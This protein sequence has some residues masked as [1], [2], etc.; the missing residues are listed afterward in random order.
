MHNIIRFST[1]WNNKLSNKAFTTI[2]L[3]SPEHYREG[4][5]YMIELKNGKEGHKF[6]CYARI[7]RIKNVK[8]EQINDYM[9]YLDTGYSAAECQNIIRK[10]YPGVKDWDRQ[11]I[12]FILLV[13]EDPRKQPEKQPVLSECESH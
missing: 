11:L 13:K 2:R 3:Y 8:L 9:S 1:N 5:T 6:L 12:S 7:Q 10:M 4:E